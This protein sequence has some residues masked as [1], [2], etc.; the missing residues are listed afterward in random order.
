MQQ[1]S[2]LADVTGIDPEAVAHAPQVRSVYVYQAP[3]RLGTG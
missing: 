3:V 1:H 2:S